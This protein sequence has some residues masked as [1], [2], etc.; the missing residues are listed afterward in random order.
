MLVKKLKRK[1][2]KVE[3]FYR[4]ITIVAVIFILTSPFLIVFSQ[5]T[6]SKINLEL[7]KKKIELNKQK[8][9]NDSLEMKIDELASL[10]EMKQVAIDKGL[11]Y[12]NSNIIRISSSR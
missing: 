2:N 11:K 6:L 3:K 12:N 9:K 8:K 4:F 7:E 10:K 5:A 1:Y